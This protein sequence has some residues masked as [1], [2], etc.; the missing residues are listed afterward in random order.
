[1]VPGATPI[2]TASGPEYRNSLAANTVVATLMSAGGATMVC[3]SAV[4]V[5]ENPKTVAVIIAE[6]NARAVARPV[7]FTVTALVSEDE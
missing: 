1:M 3:T 7:P 2:W 6:P 4:A 5:V